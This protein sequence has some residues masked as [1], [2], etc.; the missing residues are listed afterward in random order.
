MPGQARLDLL[1]AL[2]HTMVQRTNKSAIFRDADSPWA[3]PAE[4]LYVGLPP[5]SCFW[6]LHHLG[7]NISIM[8]R[9]IARVERKKENWLMHC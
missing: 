2:H 8:N 4:M 9:A 5:P 3:T 7:I 6:S 1:S